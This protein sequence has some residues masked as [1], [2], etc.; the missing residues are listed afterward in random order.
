VVLDPTVGYCE[1][2]LKRSPKG[3]ETGGFFPFGNLFFPFHS[4]RCGRLA[5]DAPLFRA[6]IGPPG[7]LAVHE[8]LTGKRA[9]GAA[10]A[11]K[12]GKLFPVDAGLFL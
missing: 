12:L 9:I 1:V 10:Q 3:N 11:R 6:A 8:A 7:K 4:P 5:Q 2:R